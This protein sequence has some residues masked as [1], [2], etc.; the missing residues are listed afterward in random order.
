MTENVV[1][2]TRKRMEA[3]EIPGFGTGARV[4]LKSGGLEMVVRET[5][6]PMNGKPVVSCDWQLADGT[7]AN[8][9]FYVEQLWRIERFDV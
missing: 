9:D 6:T 8:S 7:P 4:Q 2:L 1:G 5:K 3:V